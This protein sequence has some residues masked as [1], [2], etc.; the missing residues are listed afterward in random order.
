MRLRGILRGLQVYAAAVTARGGGSGLE[1][2]SG[3]HKA[4]GAPLGV[5]RNGFQDCPSSQ[6]RRGRYPPPFPVQPLAQILPPEVGLSKD[7]GGWLSR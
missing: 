3:C 1:T 5:D 2:I 7:G 6:T 4:V